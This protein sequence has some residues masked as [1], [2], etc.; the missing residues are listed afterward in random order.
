MSGMEKLIA[1]VE[2][3]VKLAEN[4]WPALVFIAIACA[5]GIIIDR[6]ENRK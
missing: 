4:Y 6:L 3:L 5:S 1:T 2:V